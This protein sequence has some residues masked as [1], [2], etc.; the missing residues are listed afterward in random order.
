MYVYQCGACGYIAPETDFKYGSGREFGRHP[1]HRYCP[2]CFQS[3][4]W[5]G[6]AVPCHLC[7]VYKMSIRK[8]ILFDCTGVCPVLKTQNAAILN[9]CGQA[10][11]AVQSI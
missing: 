9:G 5:F 3:I 10:Y 8:G 1:Q 2:H 11:D 7:P 6:Y 4:D